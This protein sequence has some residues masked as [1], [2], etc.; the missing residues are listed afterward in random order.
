MTPRQVTVLC[1]EDDP[2]QQRLVE[3]HLLGMP[4][5]ACVVR[6]ATSEDAGWEAFLAGPPQ[7]VLV[8]YQLAGGDGLSLVRRIRQAD[9][10]APVI[11]M[12]AVAPAEV[13]EDLIRAGADDYLDKRW[14]DSKM[15]ARSV[16]TALMRA[17]G[18]R[19]R[20]PPPSPVDPVLTDR[21]RGLYQLLLQAGAA[22]LLDRIDECES[23]AAHAGG[24]EALAV[25]VDRVCQ[26]ATP[27]TY[28]PETARR[29]LRPFVLELLARLS[30]EPG[31]RPGQR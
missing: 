6:F 30:G 7:V 10:L 13:A 23:A 26:D 29:V 15:L 17:E 19:K 24:A 20:L 14:L 16:R 12:S 9:P 5:L 28:S 22:D 18:I 4:D 2:L 8:D 25:A 3:H 1:V 11:A 31:S 21:L 27:A